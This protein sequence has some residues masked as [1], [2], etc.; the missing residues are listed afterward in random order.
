MAR[1][2]PTTVLLSVGLSLVG[3][4]QICFQWEKGDV[5]F[6]V[7]VLEPPIIPK[8]EIGGKSYNLKNWQE[9]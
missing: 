8:W 1:R 6:F 2:Q 5:G 4:V 9:I 7:C 3:I